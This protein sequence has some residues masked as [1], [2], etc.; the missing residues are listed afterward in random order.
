MGQK[1]FVVDRAT[2]S[3]REG[4]GRVQ[5]NIVIRV[6]WTP[7]QTSS[8]S[9]STHSHLSIP[10]SLRHADKMIRT[11]PHAGSWFG[12]KLETRLLSCGTR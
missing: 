11:P 3:G 2:L 1:D 5:L 10:T 12:R 4:W 9:R 8:V 6:V 7:P